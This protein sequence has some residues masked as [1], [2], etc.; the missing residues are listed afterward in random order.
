MEKFMGALYTT[1]YPLSQ[2]KVRTKM[3][4]PGQGAG[5]KKICL[6][7]GNLKNYIINQLENLKKAND[8]SLRTLADTVMQ[9]SE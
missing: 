7:D 8:K 3:P 9:W 6:K 2:L 4:A 5:K 1:R